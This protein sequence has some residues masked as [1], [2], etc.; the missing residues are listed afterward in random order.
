[1]KVAAMYL[2]R[3]YMGETKA[4]RV[5]QTGPL[6]AREGWKSTTCHPLKTWETCVCTAR[7]DQ[8]RQGSWAPGGEALVCVCVCVCVRA[9]AVDRRN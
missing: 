9:R 6:G 8:S 2:G 5:R 1:M 7:A 4:R 3:E